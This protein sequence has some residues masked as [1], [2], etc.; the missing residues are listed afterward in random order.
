VEVACFCGVVE[1]FAPRGVTFVGFGFD[2]VEDFLQLTE[3]FRV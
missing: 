3:N 2:S 1:N